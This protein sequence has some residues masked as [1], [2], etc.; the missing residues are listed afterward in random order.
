MLG[1]PAR[2]R[3]RTWSDPHW[4][5]GRR[6]LIGSKRWNRLSTHPVLEAHEWLESQET[7]TDTVIGAEDVLVRV[8]AAVLNPYDWVRWGAAGKGPD[9]NRHLADGCSTSWHVAVLAS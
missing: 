1:P 6:D 8:H 7:V 2:T 5:R 9:L 4:W 3:G